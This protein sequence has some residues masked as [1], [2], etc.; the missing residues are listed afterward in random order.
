V[1]DPQMRHGHKSQN[2][3]W[4]GYKAHVS[5]SAESE[6]ITAVHVTAA[7]VHDGAA[8]PV[9]MEGHERRGLKPQAYVG[10]MAYSAAELRQHASERGTEVVARVPRATAPAGCFSKDAFTVDLEA[11]SITCPAGQTTERST[12][13]A[14]GRA[15]YYFDGKVCAGCALR[16]ACTGHS[17]ELMRRTGRGRSIGVH[18][19][20]PILQRA[21]DLE[22]TERVQRLLKL[23][24][25]VERRL[26]HLMY[27]RGLRQARYR[28]DRKT[29]FQA[30]AAALVVNLVRMASLLGDPALPPPHRGR[31]TAMIATLARLIS[32]LA[33]AS[34][35]A[36]SRSA[37]FPCRRTSGSFRSDS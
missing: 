15:T 26:A 33:A 14:S 10:D 20:E 29:Q 18:P 5:V 17:P 24:P 25:I 31:L 28:G 23:R 9:L 19:L 22:A 35:M 8:A 30:L 32:R 11:G 6:F 7:N 37:T 27:G 1:G 36:P 21:R 4:E 3:A 2:R 12:R 34:R 13:R 16:E